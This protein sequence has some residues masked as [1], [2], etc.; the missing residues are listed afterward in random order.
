M[1]RGD[2]PAGRRRAGAGGFTLVEVLIAMTIVALVT[3]FL[4]GGLIT[5][6][7]HARQSEDR[8][9]ATAWAQAQIE[10]L[11]G[12]CFERLA[13][14]ARKIVPASLQPG[15]PPL[16]TGFAAGT[17]R[18]EP[19]EPAGLKA[20][21]SVY[22]RDWPGRDPPGPAAFTTSTYLADLRVAGACP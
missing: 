4:F 9:A 15:E 21:V 6:L 17:L 16:P 20:I 12:R 22:T 8:G 19:A 18:L 2:A 1:M 13:P 11:R 7:T 5:S 14:L 10:L 3:P